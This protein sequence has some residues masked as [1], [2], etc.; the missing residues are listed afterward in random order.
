VRRYNLSVQTSSETSQIKLETER[1]DLQLKEVRG[2]KK[3]VVVL[4][5]CLAVCGCATAEFVQ[6]V[7]IGTTKEEVISTCGSPMAWN[8]QTINGKVYE[9]LNYNPFLG[10]FDFVDDILVGYS[11]RDPWGNLKYH[12]INE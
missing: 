10:N 7:K 8:R 5:L 2:M 4:L 6:N 3:C 12:S 11:R 1:Q 9:S